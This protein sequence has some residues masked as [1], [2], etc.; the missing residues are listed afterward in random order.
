M[1]SSE[2]FFSGRGGNFCDRSGNFD[3]SYYTNQEILMPI[4]LGFQP[5]ST[6]PFAA[7]HSSEGH[8]QLHSRERLARGAMVPAYDI[9]QIMAGA[10]DVLRSFHIGQQAN[11]GVFQL[12][13]IKCKNTA[14]KQ[15]YFLNNFFDSSK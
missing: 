9:H 12:I 5:I 3:A 14:L 10:A 7:P 13:Q 1:K 11:T 8:Q 4:L 6:P 15:K 2:S